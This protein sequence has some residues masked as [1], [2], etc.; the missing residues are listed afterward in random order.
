MRLVVLLWLWS[1]FVAV[2][3]AEQ[4]FQTFYISAQGTG[5]ELEDVYYRDPATTEVVKVWPQEGEDSCLVRN[6]TDERCLSP[7]FVNSTHIQASPNYAWVC[8][9][10]ELSDKRP[11]ISEVSVH[12]NIFVFAEMHMFVLKKTTGDSTVPEAEPLYAYSYLC[13]T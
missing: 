12:V 7:V 1:G 9:D 8:R 3:G 2:R 6:G 10:L 5:R 11:S 4:A 13:N